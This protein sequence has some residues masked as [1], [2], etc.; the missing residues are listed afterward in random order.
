MKI[1][2]FFFT[3]Y[4]LF[5]GFF[6]IFANIFAVIMG[7]GANF[8]LPDKECVQI[9]ETFILEHQTLINILS[10]SSYIVPFCL[11]FLYILPTAKLKKTDKKFIQIALHIPGV[12]ALIGI[13]G[14]VINFFIELGFLIY[15]KNKTGIDNSFIIISSA[16]SM[17]FLAML[18]FTIIFFSLETLNRNLILPHFYPEGN[19]SNVQRMSISSIRNMF[20]FYFFSTSFF[21]TAYLGI[22]IFMII[23][24]GLK[25]DSY[26]DLIIALELLILGFILTLILSGFFSKPL[27]KLTDSANRIAKGDYDCTTQI[28]TNDEMGLLGD[29]F[30]A[31][32]KSLKEKEFMHDTFGKIVTPQVRDYL[33]KGHVALGGETLPVTVMFCDIRGFTTLSESMEAE[34]V[35]SLLNQYFTGLEKCITAHNGVINKYIGDAVMALF[36][37]PVKLP[38]HAEEAFNAALDMRKALL[39]INEDFEKQGLPSINFGIGIH[40]GKVLAGNIGAASRMEYTVIGDTVN[41]ASRLEGLCKT[42]KTDLLISQS[43]AEALKNPDLAQKLIFVDDALV[44]G[45]SETVKVYTTNK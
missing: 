36:G 22:R 26:S 31:M 37:A 15:L 45:K 27:K 35:V 13:L 10:T 18:S 14:W 12:F 17:M 43:T 32:A 3:H 38:N 2:E 28:C 9:W 16:S 20:L 29:S 25:V 5:F 30:N 39:K 41:T 42:Y 21:P 23:R 6:C 7:N 8:V 24:Y 4:T 33:L 44:R 40:S 34:K 11:C 19:I 1:K